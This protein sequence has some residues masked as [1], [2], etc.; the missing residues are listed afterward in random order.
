MKGDF[1]IKIAE[2]KEAGKQY[3]EISR[4]L[5]D[6]VRR[7]EAVRK[8]LSEQSYRE[9]KN[10]LVQLEEEQKNS[11][12]EIEAMGNTLFDI[13]K[14]YEETEK[15]IAQQ[16]LGEK[17]KLKNKKDFLKSIDDFLKKLI[18][19]LKGMQEDCCQY[20]GDPVNLSTGNFV[21]HREYL[22][23]KGLYP[24]E[25]KMFYNSVEQKTGVLG[26]GWVH[27][28]QIGLHKEDQRAVLCW[29]DGRED[30]FVKDSDGQYSHLIG[31][32]DTLEEV[33]EGLVYQTVLGQSYIFDSS[34]KAIK[35]EDRNGNKLF[36]F[37]DE[38]GRLQQIKSISGEALFYEYNEA[39][40]LEKVSDGE[41]RA[42]Y[43][44]YKESC[45]TQVK[46]EEN[47]VFKYGYDTRGNLNQIVNGRKITSIQNEYDHQGRVTKQYYPDGG[48][49]LMEYDD[50][51]KTVHVT[52]QNGNK[53]DYIHDENFRSVE[54]VYA[55]GRVQYAYNQQNQKIQ[56]IDKK[57]NQTRYNYDEAGNLILV[58]NPLGEKMEMAYNS[59]RQ[60][61]GI[62]ICGEVYQ[63]SK[64]DNRGNLICR[65]DA[66]GR[67]FH[68][69]YNENGKPVEIVQP[70][71][72]VIK[73][74]YDSHGNISTIREPMGGETHYEYDSLGQVIATI[75]GNGNRTEYAYNHRGHIIAVTNAEGNTKHFYYN[76]S[77]KVTCIE[78]Y[79][80]SRIQWKYNE[81]NKPCRIINQENQTIHLEYDCMWNMTRR[82]EPNGGETRFIYDKLNRLERI[83]NAKGA[84]FCYEYDV[85]GNRTRIVDSQGGSVKMEYDALNRLVTIEDADGAV[86]HM[87][88]NRFGQRTRMTDALG[89]TRRVIYDKAGQKIASIDAKGN[90]T[91]YQYNAMGK[92]CETV[93]PAGRRT[94]CEY[95]PGGLPAKITYP[96]G[97]FVCYTYDLNRNIKTKSNQTGYTLTYTYD[98]MNRITQIESNEG[99]IK[100]Y[101]YDAAGNVKAVTDANGN[102]TWYQYSAA[103]NLTAVI[104]TLGNRIEY[105]YDNMGALA[106][107]CRC[108]QEELSEACELN[109]SNRNPYFVQYQRD[110]LGHIEK[111]TDALGKEEHYRYDNMGRLIE[112]LDKEG[113]STKYDYTK[114][115]QLSEIQYAD[116]N[117]VKLSY[118]P[119]KQLVEI[120]DWLSVTAIEVD[121]LG[122]PEKVTDTEGREVI[123]TRGELGQRTQLQYPDGKTVKYGYDNEMRLI[124]LRDENGEIQYSYDENGKLAGKLLPNG[125]KTDYTYHTTGA[126]AS[127]TYRNS[128]GVLESFAY[129]YDLAGNKTGV[130]RQRRDLPGESGRYSYIYDRLNRLTTVQKDNGNLRS[131]GYDAFGNRTFL[132]EAGVRTEYCYNQVNQLLRSDNGESVIEYSYDAR[133][134]LTE[135]TENGKIKHNYEYNCM[136]RLA[137][138]ADSIGTESVYQYNGLGHRIGQQI[139]ENGNPVRDIVYVLDQAKG[140]HNLLLQ[141]EE[142]NIRKFIWDG[143]VAGEQGKNGIHYYLQDELGSPL[144]YTD[145]TGETV[146]SY[147]FDEF[148]NS[149][150]SKEQKQPF[151]YTGFYQDSVAG[152]YFAQAREYMPETGRFTACDIVK[153]MQNAPY[154]LNEYVYCWNRPLTFTDQNG[155][156][157]SWKDIQEG[158]SDAADAVGEWVGDAADFAGETVSAVTTTFFNGANY[159][160][161]NYVPE[162]V[163]QRVGAATY[164]GIKAFRWSIEQEV[165]GVSASDV[166]AWA[167]QSWA[168]EAFLDA[169]CFDRTSDGV[170]HADQSCWQAPFGYNQFYDYVFHGA[171]SMKPMQYSFTTADGS[172]Y[173]IWMWKGDYLNLGAGCETGIY[174]GKGFHLNSATD[175]NLYMSLSLYDKETGRRIF[176]Y[177]PND[178]QWWITGFNPEYQDRAEST[179]E[180][181]GSIDFSKEP[182]M[183]E[184]F[185]GEYKEQGGWCFDEEEKIA[186]YQW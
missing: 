12:R 125:V 38:K 85:N 127:I 20:G 46:D 185:F 184:A 83:I 3:Q 174:Y 104:D 21:Y 77:G 178:P 61:I 10:V 112:K 68:V 53:I 102:T 99:Q 66:L 91:T 64:Y 36:F 96:D 123:Y 172:N 31:K 177:N 40:L 153:G 121:A 87:E 124:S 59:M 159:I 164:V 14:C 15:K 63:Q 163:Q 22:R 109:E 169:V 52:E 129:E 136:N 7:L 54:T 108:G 130:Q 74:E 55:D 4:F 6:C 80:G 131:Y 70:D 88:Y 154:T 13:V 128:E 76:E 23:Q 180:V 173:T 110:V 171:T 30:I 69:S 182:E 34:G 51:L 60:I 5:T 167:S 160:W 138:A 45:L 176:A 146:E 18:K 140:Y 134:N 81:I 162:G 58:E 148:G 28:Y 73:L 72:S 25:F 168:G 101:A 49:M 41:G 26:K 157:P 156:F 8:E 133:G 94:I 118:N 43:L 32:H 33:P 24:I 44:S 158:M 67:K 1:E 143:N 161:Q 9:I 48:I 42:V 75:D 62:W 92:V 78:E 122:R 181:H 29:S 151:G 39:G 19:M 115:G 137:Y 111:T 117:T 103:G 120:R 100:R 84:E 86:S 166:M 116:G 126:L 47:H 71:E 144:R 175:T 150:L 132:E 35:A 65:Q 89:N 95:L 179:L 79:D 106:Q 2:V 170:Y 27:N 98:S 149:T 37:Y 135:I 107:I 90:K 142:N 17:T 165:M 97:T 105:T 113:F 186:Y 155:A 93:D 139:K 57:G 183:W 11:I 145:A 141:I 56:I 147:G 119:L 16:R 152:T 50:A 82:T 114:G